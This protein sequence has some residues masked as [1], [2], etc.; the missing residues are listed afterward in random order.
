[1]ENI[2]N[3]SGFYVCEGEKALEKFCVDDS[4]YDAAKRMCQPPDAVNNCAREKPTGTNDP[5][6]ALGEGIYRVPYPTIV[7]SDAPPF[8]ILCKNGNNKGSRRRVFH[9]V[10]VDDQRYFRGCPK[11]GVFN[12]RYVQHPEFY[13]K[14]RD[15]IHAKTKLV[16]ND[17]LEQGLYY[18]E[19]LLPEKKEEKV[20]KKEEKM[21]N[22]EQEINEGP[23]KK[24]ENEGKENNKKEEKMGGS[25]LLSADYRD[26]TKT[27][28]TNEKTL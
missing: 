11:N 15:G 13:F 16:N 17:V 12:V 7:G 2:N 14:C 10:W 20:E 28:D 4:L 18:P 3:C 21:N 5:C 23:K 24:M 22:K 6:P 9:N 25:D 8:Y 27:Y 26:K 1:M 19:E